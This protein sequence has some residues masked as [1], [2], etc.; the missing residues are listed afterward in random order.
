MLLPA[1][2]Q[3]AAV[4]RVKAVLFVIA[5]LPL[6]RLLV[7]GFADQLGANPIEFVIRSNGTWAL[8]FV[9]I[10][11]AVTPLRRLAGAGWLA[12]LRR[13]LGLYAFF[14]A[15]LHVLSYIWLD[16]WFDWAAIGKDIV[17][18]PFILAGF[19]AFLLL[20][21]LAVTSTDAMLRR[22]GK[23]W[24]K[25]H[26]TLYLIAPIAVLHYF[27]LVKKDI[28]QPV[29]YALLL[30]L[31]LGLRLLWKVLE[32]PGRHSRLLQKSPIIR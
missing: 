29:I 4:K 31:L 21:P 13:M 14:Y 19:T 32:R 11:L 10:T 22:L 16:Q 6:A 26:Q 20:V 18:H 17:K 28:T 25:L 7:L 27:W 23:R 5:L 15:C 1:S 12:G 24:K 9:L 8:S 3:L 2:L 30:A